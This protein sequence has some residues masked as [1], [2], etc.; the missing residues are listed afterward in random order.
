MNKPQQKNQPRFASPQHGEILS[1]T[2]ENYLLSLYNLYE[3]KIRVTLS[4][5]AEHLRHLPAHEGVGTSLPSVVAMIRRM[6][7]ETLVV[8]DSN[9]EIHLTDKGLILAEDM[10]RRH[11]LAERMVVDLLGV[12]L[13]RAHMEAHRLEHAISPE[14]LVHIDKTLGH[15]IA[16]P[17]GGPIPGS[18]YELPVEES[19]PLSKAKEGIKYKVVRVPEEDQDLLRFLVENQILPNVELSVTQTAPYLGIVTF[20]TPVASGSIGIVVASRIMLCIT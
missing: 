2:V 20:T 13:D 1:P 9:K 7:K 18:G 14:L 4:R 10:V 16:C 19:V 17:F 6:Q 15:P 11:R 8:T 5:L 3:E 12:P